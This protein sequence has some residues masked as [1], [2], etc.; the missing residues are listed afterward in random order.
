MTPEN[1]PVELELE[2]DLEN[3]NRLT[4]GFRLILVIPQIIVAGFLGLVGAVLGFLGWWAALFTRRIPHWVREYMDGYIAYLARIHAYMLLLVD[5]YP[6][7]AFT[8]P[9][10]PVQLEMPEPGKL[11]RAAVFF[12]FFLILPFSFLSLF[13]AYGSY[14]VWFFAWLIVLITGRLP[15]AVFEAGA[16]V[17]RFNA[18]VTAYTYMLTANYPKELFGDKNPEAVE[19]RSKT[20]PLAL[21]QNGRRLLIALIVIGVI[22]VVAYQTAN[23]IYVHHMVEQQLQHRMHM[24]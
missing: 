24:H 16:A 17:V 22:A 6:P 19:Q 15:R 9:E 8:L 12:R 21:S 14:P 10:S 7:F 20:R 18:R 2:P 5:D 1:G 11:N 13:L 23:Q 3:R 4:V